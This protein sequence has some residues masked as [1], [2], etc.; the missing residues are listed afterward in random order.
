MGE[1]FVSPKNLGV[2]LRMPDPELVLRGPLRGGRGGKGKGEKGNRK[3]E[4]G[5]EGGKGRE[6]SWNRAADWLRSALTVRQ[7]RRLLKT[8]YF[9]LHF[10]PN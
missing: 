5:Q 8:H 3:G 9:Q 1:G 4:E 6:K 7:F 2:E 10:G